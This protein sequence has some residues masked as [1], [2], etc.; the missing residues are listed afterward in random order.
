MG[1]EQQLGK[2]VCMGRSGG[3]RMGEAGR[4]EHYQ[5]GGLERTAGA[6]LSTLGP[7]VFFLRRSG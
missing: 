5:H 4:N 6:G 1:T 7:T 2:D 3:W